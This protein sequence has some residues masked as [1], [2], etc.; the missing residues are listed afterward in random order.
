MV[1]GKPGDHLDGFLDVYTEIYLPYN[2]IFNILKITT[3]ETNDDENNMI[4][5]PQ[6]RK[7]P[8]T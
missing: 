8:R 4:R 2:V 3:Y 1:M 5:Y 6:I 7:Y